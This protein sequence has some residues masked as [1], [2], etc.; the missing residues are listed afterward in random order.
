MQAGATWPA[1]APGWAHSKHG[2]RQG[3]RSNRPYTHHKAPKH[4]VKDP[5]DAGRCHMASHSPG[6]GPQQRGSAGATWPATAA[7][8]GRA[9][10]TF[11]PWASRVTLGRR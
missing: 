3:H 10:R 7:D 5:P 6:P 8:T 1:T 2:S 9:R 4:G 11:G